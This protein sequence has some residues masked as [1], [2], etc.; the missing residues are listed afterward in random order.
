MLLC[1]A[2]SSRVPPHQP[3]ASSQ[4]PDQPQCNTDCPHAALTSLSSHIW[5]FDLFSQLEVVGSTWTVSDTMWPLWSPGSAV[6][7]QLW[8]GPVCAGASGGSQTGA[9]SSVTCRPPERSVPWQQ[10]DNTWDRQCGSNEQETAVMT[11]LE[12]ETSV[13]SVSSMSDRY[14]TPEYLAHL[15]TSVSRFRMM[16][17]MSDGKI[18]RL[19][20]DLCHDLWSEEI[21]NYC[22]YTCPRIHWVTLFIVLLVTSQ[23]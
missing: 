14:I 6:T 19:H 13:T 1:T 9:W 10:S 17:R 5:S 7:V 15:P 20:D 18:D 4:Q 23:I 8:P 22:V 3:A 16:Q 2:H 12:T 21:C 11:V